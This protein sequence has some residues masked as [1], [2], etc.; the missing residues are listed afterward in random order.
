MCMD[1]V[2]PA[3]ALCDLTQALPITFM[4]K[5]MPHPQ[6]VGETT[7]QHIQVQTV[8]STARK[9]ALPIKFQN[10]VT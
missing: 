7:R 1:A 10:V 4:G 6:A 3:L 2:K 9:F 8:T 5:R